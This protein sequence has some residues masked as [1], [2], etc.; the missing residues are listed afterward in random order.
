MKRGISCGVLVV[1]IL[2]LCIG[3]N[4]VWAEDT[5]SRIYEIESRVDYLENQ[6][7]K[8]G[9]WW[10]GAAE[11]QEGKH[12]IDVRGEF[13][14]IPTNNPI[15]HAVAWG[16]ISIPFQCT[17]TEILF[18]ARNDHDT[19][20]I[21]GVYDGS[22]DSNDYYTP[23]AYKKVSEGTPGYEIYSIETGGLYYDPSTFRKPWWIRV[24][25]SDS[26]DYQRIQWVKIL[27]TIP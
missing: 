7:P 1:A 13:F 5:S 25:L 24:N 15:W 6:T 14:G 17:I 8:I 26:V 9:V 2:T 11:F 19:D 4:I 21:L 22:K 20:I 10:I 18:R 16:P 3:P 23:V 12:D 27:Y